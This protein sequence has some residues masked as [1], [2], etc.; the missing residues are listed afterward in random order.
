MSGS[1]R[2]RN[3]D[4]SEE[5]LQQ[6]LDAVADSID[7]GEVSDV[8]VVGTSPGA[9]GNSIQ[10][11]VEVVTTQNDL[12]AVQEVIGSP[13]FIAQVDQG[14][15]DIDVSAAGPVDTVAQ[16][17]VTLYFEPPTVQGPVV[18]SVDAD[19]AAD[20]DALEEALLNA[21]NELLGVDVDVSNVEIIAVGEGADPT[22]NEVAIIVE[23]TN[24]DA[25]EVLALLASPDLAG[26]LDGILGDG[27]TVSP[28]LEQGEVQLVPPTLV[29]VDGSPGLTP[30]QLVE[31]IVAAMPEVNPLDVV[32]VPTAEDPTQFVIS[33]A[34]PDGT[35]VTDLEGQVVFADENGQPTANVVPTLEELQGE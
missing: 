21:L 22:T 23:S 5:Q 10:I 6:I 18:L 28:T 25:E 24:A 7:A 16:P 14:V 27:T 8:V 15:P 2:N 20:P 17:P 32:V 29:E 31:A 9:D 1:E 34:V 35:T 12:E 11:A 13:D 3:H 33:V 4:L 19:S 26:L 30:E